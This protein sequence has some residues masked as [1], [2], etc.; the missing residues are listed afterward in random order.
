MRLKQTVKQKG[1]ALLENECIELMNHF[2]AKG[3]IKCMLEAG[4]LVNGLWVFIHF[5]FQNAEIKYV[6]W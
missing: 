4:T 1:M 2:E 6:L 3:E 5:T